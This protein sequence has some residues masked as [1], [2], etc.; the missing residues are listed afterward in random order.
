MFINLKKIYIKVKIIFF[1]Q[2]KAKAFI[3]FYFPPCKNNI[4]KKINTSKLLLKSKLIIRFYTYIAF[5]K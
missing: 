2:I 5:H 4:N 1:I 3:I